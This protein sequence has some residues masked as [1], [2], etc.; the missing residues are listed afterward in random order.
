[1]TRRFRMVLAFAVLATMLPALSASAQAQPANPIKH[2]I[3]VYMENW[4]FDSLYGLFPNA[5]GLNNATNAAPQID[6]NGNVYTV[7]PAPLNSN[8]RDANGAYTV[9]S[10]F[11]NNL[12][13]K[14]FLITQYVPTT[15]TTG[16]M[17]HRYYQ[18]QYQIDGGKMDK[19]VAWSDAAGLVM[20]HVDI[21]KEPMYKYATQY[22]VGDHF[23]HAAF[24]GSFLNAFWLV[25][26]CTPTFP[27]APADVVAQVDANGVIT[28]DGSVTPD[29]YAVNTTYSVNSPHPSTAKADHLLPS[30]TM[31]NIGDSLSAAG[32]SWAWYSGGWNNA[33]AGKPD[34]LFQF[35]HQ[36]FAYFKNYADGT[37]AKAQH[38][39]DETDFYASLKDGSLPAVSWVKPIGEDNE[40]P[41]YAALDTGEQWLANLVDTVQKSSVWQDTAIIVTYDENGG[42]WDHVAPP[43]VDKWGPGTRVPLLV[44][45][46][47]AKKSFIDHDQMDTTS[48]LAFIETRFGLKPLADR[49]AHAN[50]MM[51]AFD[52][53][54]NP[55]QATQGAASAASTMAATM[56]PTTAA[57]AAPTMAATKSS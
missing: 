55:A 21:T 42:Q 8:K 6:K 29:G 54:Q 33:L 25:C 15:D 23:F 50:N 35:H 5:D 30:Q 45:S 40:H 10:R 14:P 27:N 38:L 44:I 28:K 57:T 47:Y 52:F 19:F 3:V 4:S 7:L 53:S 31:P 39:K 48:I 16:D 17:W 43:V 26:A 34:P 37:D 32:V 22:T 2:I 13:N 12:P 36:V 51:G 24:G 20:G 41:G 11:P 9:D 18:E 46:P 49:D 1:M 56:A